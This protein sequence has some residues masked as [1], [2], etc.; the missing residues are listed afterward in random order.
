MTGYKNVSGA[1]PG[2]FV[3]SLNPTSG[4]ITRDPVVQ[5]AWFDEGLYPMPVTLSGVIE[6][7]QSYSLLLQ[8]GSVSEVN[9]ISPKNYKNIEAWTAAQ[10][11]L[12]HGKSV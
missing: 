8:D 1:T 9:G 3:I 6:Q 7:D 5:W 12:K 10:K 11:D 4:E 2:I